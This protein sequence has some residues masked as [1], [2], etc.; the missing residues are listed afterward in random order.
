MLKSISMLKLI[1]KLD[2][3]RAIISNLAISLVAGAL[4]VILIKQLTHSRIMVEPIQVPPP[5]N[6]QGF[7]PE[8][9]AQ[10]V[11][12]EMLTIQKAATTRKEGQAIAPE[13]QQFDMDV[14]GSGLSIS[15][16]GQAVRE[17]LGLTQ[18][19]IGGEVIATP[20][21]YQMRI[22][23]SGSQIT[24]ASVEVEKGQIEQLIKLA[25]EE[26][27]QRIDPFM[28]AS[29]L[30]ATKQIDRL[31]QAI[32]F[33]L[34]EGPKEDRPWALNLLGISQVEAQDLGAAKRSY[35]DAIEEDED[36]AL[37][38]YNLSNL[39]AME[40]NYQQTLDYYLTAI[41]LDN[42]LTDNIKE[43]KIRINV[44]NNLVRAGDINKAFKMYR[45]ATRKHPKQITSLMLWGQALKRE[46]N[47]DYEGAADKFEQATEIEPQ[48]ARAFF[49]W[50]KML[51][52]LSECA[53]AIEKYQQAEL[54]DPDGYQ[55]SIAVEINKAKTCVN[56]G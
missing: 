46:P 36:F 1:E 54:L 12:D 4:V 56:D 23:L 7:T 44:A 17:S 38:Y 48:N 47:P 26:A 16:I 15:A 25:A 5:L 9:T 6:E 14:P 24:Y 21:S 52:V 31:D 18:R 10:W 33:S 19:R 41:K 27:V 37:A 50:G 53:A 13:W 35:L 42:N 40:R 22:R 8:I 51:L 45:I 32:T 34:S 39:Y 55:G 2:Q 28:F 49:E 29:Y 30:H 3:F 11:M 43:A 20:S